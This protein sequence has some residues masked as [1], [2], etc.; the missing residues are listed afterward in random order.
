[1]KH[2]HIGMHAL[3]KKFFGNSTN[4]LIT[5]VYDIEAWQGGLPPHRL[6]CVAQGGTGQ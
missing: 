6:I 2:R 1:M 3:L 4:F 5:D